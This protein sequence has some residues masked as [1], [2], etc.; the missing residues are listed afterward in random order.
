MEEQNFKIKAKIIRETFKDTR[1]IKC[2]TPEK[3]RK[4][5]E[6]V[7][8]GGDIFT[9]EEG[10]FIDLEFQLDD[11][12]ID[13]L[14]KYIEF[15]EELYEKHH[16]HV[17]VYLLCPE[18]VN[19][20]VKEDTIK[21]EADFT[22]RL[23]C[24]EQNFARITLEMLKDKLEREEGDESKKRKR[25]KMNKKKKRMIKTKEKRKKEKKDKKKRI[26]KKK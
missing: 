21:S 4:L 10:E 1:K 16:K 14:V 3:D 2:I 25:L 22:I 9:T 23:A 5:D 11:F 20:C 7:H 19:I 24:F 15:A 12:T 18:I 6:H 8:P 26:R 17:S 13:E